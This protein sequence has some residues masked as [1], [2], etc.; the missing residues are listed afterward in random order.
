MGLPEIN[1]EFIGKAVTA[2]KRSQLGIVALILKDDVQ[3]ADT[4]TYKSIEEVPTDGWS[5][6]NLDYIEKTFMGTPSKIIIER[7]PTTAAD[8]NAALTRLN[9]KRFNYL[10]IPGIEDKDTT[11]IATWIKTKRENQ[12]KTFK[13]VLPNNEAD[14]EGIINFTTTGIKVGEKE[15]TTAE[16]TARIAGIMA[17]L[18]FTRSSTYFVL[19]EV[20]SINE[21][22]DPDKAVDDGELILINDGEN[23]KIGRGVNSLTTTT[24][25]KTE[26]FKSIRI[27]EVQDM[28]KD[29]IAMTFDKYYVGKLNNIYDNQVLF[30]RSINAYFAGLG[31]QEILDPNFANKAEVSVRKQRLAWEGIGTDTSEWDD[32]KVR[33]MSFKRNVFLGGNIKIVDAME[34]LDLDIAI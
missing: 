29:D 33:E 23:I 3:T 32:Q 22:E 26:D 28:I 16:Y 2:I 34:D 6:A 10:A 4:V 27:M 20:D 17:G 7:L 19:S 31:D 30:I 24:G 18:P 14:H 25:S 12:K 1:I 21:L 9:N 5:P 13:A 11:I 8:Y 15:Y